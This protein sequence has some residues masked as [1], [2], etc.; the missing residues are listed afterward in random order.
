MLA[1]FLGGCAAHPTSLVGDAS[2]DAEPSVGGRCATTSDC[3][4]QHFC[5]FQRALG[6]A[7]IGVCVLVPPSQASCGYAPVCDC[8]G[9]TWGSACPQNGYE[10]IRVAHMGECEDGGADAA[11]DAQAD[12]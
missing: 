9:K 1:A 3:D 10:Y 4:A 8:D 2:A 7:A 6:C 5:G 12:R 11:A